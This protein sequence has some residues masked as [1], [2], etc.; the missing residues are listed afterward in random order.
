MEI[1]QVFHDDLAGGHLSINKVYPKLA[2]RYFWP[3]MYAY[4]KEW[5]ASCLDCASKKSP[6]NVK[7]APLINIPAASSAYERVAVDIVGPFVKSRSGN[8]YLLVFT[9]YLTRHAEAFAIPDQESTTIARVLVD[10][11]IFKHGAMKSL[12]SDRGQNF[13]SKVVRE[14]CKYLSIK[15]LNT[16]SFHPQTDG[17]VERFNKT[18][19]EMLSMYVETSQRDWDVYVDAALFAYNTSE[20]S[21]TKYSPFYLMYGREAKLPVDCNL[22]GTPKETITIQDYCKELEAKLRVACKEAKKNVELSQQKSKAY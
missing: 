14:T 13:L 16:T 18:L 7:R 19:V 21:S 12:L 3:G 11:V 6:T 20:C 10:K 2:K 15:K 17:L 8:K 9:D 22:F 5:I 4:A 1:M